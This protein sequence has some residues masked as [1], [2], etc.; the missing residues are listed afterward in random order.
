[1]H[2]QESTFWQK[3]NFMQINLACMASV[4]P[5]ASDHVFSANEV[6]IWKWMLYKSSQARGSF[7]LLIAR[8]GDSK[9]ELLAGLELEGRGGLSG[10][11]W[12]VRPTYAN[13]KLKIGHLT[14]FQSRSCPSRYRNYHSGT[15]SKE[16][17]SLILKCL[18]ARHYIKFVSRLCVLV[19]N[20]G[21]IF[22]FFQTHW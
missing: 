11:V 10:E 15:R 6:E 7:V 1:M 5:T 4:S 21:R 14:Q 12:G 2:Q 22:C 17:T 16:L 9:D 20:V 8:W 18:I 3:I 13:F 19:Q